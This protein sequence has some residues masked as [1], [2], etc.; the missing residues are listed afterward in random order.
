MS[1]ARIGQDSL[2]LRP[3]KFCYTWHS[4]PLKCQTLGS[5]GVGA[6]SVTSQAQPRAAQE[7]LWPLE[8]PWAPR[9]KPPPD[10]RPHPAPLEPGEVPALVPAMALALPMFAIFPETE[11]KDWDEYSGLSWSDTPR[12]GGATD[13]AHSQ[14]CK[15]SDRA[16]Q[17]CSAAQ[18]MHDTCACPCLQHPQRL[19]K[20]TGMRMVASAVLTL[21]GGV[22]PMRLTFTNVTPLR[23]YSCVQALQLI[24]TC[25][26]G[27]LP[28]MQQDSAGPQT[29]TCLH[30]Y[31]FLY[32]I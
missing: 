15:P 5:A 7:F 26:M 8:V 3:R 24:R 23:L 19:R 27:T 28:G 16:P 20:R 11:E 12:R 25:Y 18:N 17:R 30:L 2:V 22:A 9:R 32:T 14:P 31:V 13:E 10:P 21:R 6:M 1:Q 4:S 29:W